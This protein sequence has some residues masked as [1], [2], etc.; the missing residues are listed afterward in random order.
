MIAHH[1]QALTMAHMVPTHTTNARI[2]L[3]SQRIEVSQTDEIKQMQRWL[4]DRHEIAPSADAEHEHHEGMDQ[5]AR[6][7]GMLTAEELARLDG[8]KGAEFDR[9]FLT[10]MISHHEGALVMVAK[11]FGT[12]GAGQDPQLFGYASDVDADQRAEIA[13]MRT[14]L[15]APPNESPRR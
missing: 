14:M 2:H 8:A 10:F 6:M 13:R 9:L 12:N 15:V 7:P 1:A 11:L 5:R 4:V 3:L